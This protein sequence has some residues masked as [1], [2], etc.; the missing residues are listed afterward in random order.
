MR[1]PIILALAAAGPAFAQPELG[2]D[3]PDRLSGELKR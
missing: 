3:L 2:R 1:F